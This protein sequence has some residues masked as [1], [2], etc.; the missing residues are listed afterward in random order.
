MQLAI[1]HALGTIYI[2]LV[3]TQPPENEPMVNLL[4]VIFT[5]TDML[6]QDSS[7]QMAVI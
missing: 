1:H 2:E 7:S 5:V 3:S 4:N 6:K